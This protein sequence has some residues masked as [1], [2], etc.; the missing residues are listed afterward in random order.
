MNC[1]HVP[2][3]MKCVVPVV[4]QQTKIVTHVL[5]D[6]YSIQAIVGFVKTSPVIRAFK[7]GSALRNAEMEELLTILYQD[8]IVMMEI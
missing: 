1:R 4:D 6:Q 3:A 8:T 5:R 2:L 7:M